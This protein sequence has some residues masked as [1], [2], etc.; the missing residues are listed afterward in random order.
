MRRS[1]SIRAIAGRFRGGGLAAESA[2]SLAYELISM[3]GT[4]LAFTFLGRSLGV[5]G[6]GG[7]ASLYAI[8]GPMVTLAASGVTLSLLQH[9]VRDGEP[10]DQTARSCLSLAAVLGLALTAVGAALAFWVVDTLGAVAIL[11]ILLIEFVT[12]PLV[13][14]AASTVQAGTSFAGAARIRILLVVGR[15]VLLTGLFVTDSL[16]VASLGLSQLAW[17]A[18]LSG[19][20]LRTVG[21]RYGFRFWPGRIRPGHLKSNV[22]Y[23]TAISADAFGNDGDKVVL[24]ANRFVIDTGLYA[25]AYRIIMLG[26][27][28]IGS[29]VNVS[30]K[31]FLEHE[32]GRRREHLDLAVR[33]SVLGGAYG[34]VFAVVVFFAAPL[35][36]IVVGDDFEGSV[37]MVRWLAPIVFLR[38]IGIFSLNGLMGLGRVTLRTVL[39]SANAAFGLVLY[40]VLIPRYGWEGALIGTLVTETLQV[41]MTWTA[42]VIVQRGADRAMEAE[43]AAGASE[44]A[45][46][47][48]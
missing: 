8:I 6:Y 23:S 40:V 32:E 26:L 16:T 38:A 13:N 31:R 46:A 43:D 27:V 4:L 25:A 7:Y 20:A 19:W 22:L 33:F 24:A 29:L 3:A 1:T 36:P 21:R 47:T 15:M 41:V 10:L 45:P 39:I 30:H 34:I 2:W 44:A 35:F 17:S 37:T 11:S 18:L 9:V 14:V 28:P 42:L 5:A 12:S 48:S